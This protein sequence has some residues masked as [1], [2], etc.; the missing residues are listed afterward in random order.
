MPYNLEWEPLGV[1]LRF[2]G[3]VSDKDLLASNRA[4]I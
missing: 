3:V 4:T 2:S 1:V